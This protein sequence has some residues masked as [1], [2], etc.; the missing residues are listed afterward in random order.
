MGT[1]T[2][3]LLI[4]FGIVALCIFFGYVEIRIRNRWRFHRPVICVCRV[5]PRR[6]GVVLRDDFHRAS[7]EYWKRRLTGKEHYDAGHIG[8]PDG[9]RIDVS[10]VFVFEDTS[11]E[12]LTLV[13]RCYVE[14]ATFH[15]PAAFGDNLNPIDKTCRCIFGKPFDG[16]FINW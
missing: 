3:S 5:G 4:V 14:Q 10:P 15:V 6:T 8:A 1:L 7:R 12:Y 2:F 13:H 16:Q 9:H 11:R